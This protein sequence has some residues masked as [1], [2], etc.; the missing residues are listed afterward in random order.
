M[1]GPRRC[2][3]HSNPPLLMAFL[4]RTFAAAVLAFALAP[5]AFGQAYPS[6]DTPIAIPDGN[7]GGDVCGDPGPA[8]TSTITVTDAGTISDLDIRLNL[9]HTWIGDLTVTLSNGTTTVALISRPGADDSGAACGS[10]DDVSGSV[11]A[12]DE[13]MSGTFEDNF[14]W[15]V[16]DRFVPNEALSAFDGQALAG[17]WTLTVT[18]GGE[19]DLGTLNEWELLFNGAFPTASEGLLEGL[20]GNYLGSRSYPNPFAGRTSV[21][22]TVAQAQDVTIEVYNVLGQRVATLFE[23]AMQANVLQTF[24]FDASGLPSGTYL[25]RVDGET[26]NDTHRITLLG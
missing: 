22:L 1:G 17:T 25:I 11:Y 8:A 9:M 23:G 13:G 3:S 18:D 10:G 26:F 19:A 5:V 6:T 24:V 7:P 21:D 12:D 20:P 16:G 14:P 4:L 2:I 15:T